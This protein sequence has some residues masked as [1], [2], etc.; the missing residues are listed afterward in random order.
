MPQEILAKMPPVRFGQAAFL[1]NG[2][3]HRSNISLDADRLL[4]DFPWTHGLFRVE[5]DIDRTG[6]SAGVL[7]ESKGTYGG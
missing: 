6:V 3:Q 4:P 1:G 5:T 2:L 7:P